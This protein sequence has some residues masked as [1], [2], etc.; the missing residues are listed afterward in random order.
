[1]WKWKLQRLAR[2]LANGATIAFNRVYSLVTIIVNIISYLLMCFGLFRGAYYAYYD[3]NVIQFL[4][5]VAMTVFAVYINLKN[6]NK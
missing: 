5:S 1:M 6:P 4:W 2:T 3:Q